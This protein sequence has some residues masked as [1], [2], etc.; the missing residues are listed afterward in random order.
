MRRCAVLL[1]RTK[2]YMRSDRYKG[3][4]VFLHSLFYRGGDRTHVVAVPDSIDMPSIGPEALSDVLG[5]GQL[6]LP[7]DGY[8]IIIVKA[9]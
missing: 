3:G 8:M 1:R 2:T 7:F 4:T 9:D 5:K 6:R